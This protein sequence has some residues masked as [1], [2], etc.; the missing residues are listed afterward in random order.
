MTR[1]Y[2]DLVRRTERLPPAYWALLEEA[3]VAQRPTWEGYCLWQ[4]LFLTLRY[5]VTPLVADLIADGVINWYAFLV[6]GRESGVPT[7]ATD[8]WAYVHLRVALTQ[9]ATPESLFSRL[10]PECLMT[11]PM[12]PPE[13]PTLDAVDISGLVGGDVRYGWRLIGDSSE[14][15]LKVIA[16]HRPDRPMS[17]RTI[18]QLFHYAANE[19][20]VRCVGIPSP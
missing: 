19:M 18:A 15:V 16:A 5:T 3:N 17:D 9:D 4:V 7:A 14:Q 20:L 11:R 13:P 12:V 6:H 8:D 2:D 1:G 10:T